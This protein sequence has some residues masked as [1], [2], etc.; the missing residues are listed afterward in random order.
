MT[1]LS[2]LKV[3]EKLVQSYFECG[4][5]YKE[6]TETRVKEIASGE[7]AERGTIDVIGN[8]IT[9]PPTLETNMSR[10]SYQG[11]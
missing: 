7:A 1:E 11:F 3:N 4:D 8:S 10:T 2:L 9:H 6:L 5:Y